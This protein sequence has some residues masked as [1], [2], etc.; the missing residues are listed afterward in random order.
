MKIIASWKSIKSEENR[1]RFY[2]I[3]LARDLWGDEVLIKRWGRIG[4]GKRESYIWLEDHEELLNKIEEIKEK[5]EKH[6]YQ[7]EG[8]GLFN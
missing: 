6:E 5:R 4:E 1:Y 3:I 2:S 8:K 7:L